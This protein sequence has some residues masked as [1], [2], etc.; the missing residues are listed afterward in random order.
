MTRLTIPICLFLALIVGTGLSIF[1][2][3]VIDATFGLH[4]LFG[5]TGNIELLLASIFF[6]GGLT[7]YITKYAL[8]QNALIETSFIKQHLQQSLIVYLLFIILVP[9][10]LGSLPLSGLQD[11]YV[12]I[13]VINTTVAVVTNLIALLILKR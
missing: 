12:V 11:S 5:A 4:S 3:I 10:F 13:I 9:V 6:T 2:V 1:P 7:F 8:K